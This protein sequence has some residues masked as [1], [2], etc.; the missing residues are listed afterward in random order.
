MK[1]TIRLMPKENDFLLVGRLYREPQFN[2]KKTVATLVV[3]RNFGGDKGA[4]KQTFTMFKPKNGDFPSFLKKGTPVEVHAYVVPVH[5]TN[6]DGEQRD[7]LQ[8]VIKT[9]KAVEADDKHQLPAGNNISFAGRV[10][11]NVFVNGNVARFSV[12][13]N[14]G[15]EKGAAV[16]DFSIFK[17]E[18]ESFPEHLKSKEP[19]TVRAYFNPNVWTD[20]DGNQRD[21]TQYIVKTL[22]K[23]VLTEKTIEVDGDAEPQGE[24][25][26]DLNNE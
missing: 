22:E 8:Y 12:I 16:L 4:V 5:W 15:G 25:G 14:F 9:I 24:E 6:K 11:G 7:D 19:V 1:K 13:R 20:K 17:K 2:E 3:I 18:G 21:E 23:A 10:Y 26:V